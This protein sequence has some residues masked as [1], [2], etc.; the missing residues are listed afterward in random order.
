MEGG[1]HFEV[2]VSYEDPGELLLG[3]HAIVS[4][5]ARRAPE[6][7]LGR[8]CATF[9]RQLETDEELSGIQRDRGEVRRG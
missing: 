1:D 5:I 3:L 7:D 4:M 2:T 6:G 9:A 8:R